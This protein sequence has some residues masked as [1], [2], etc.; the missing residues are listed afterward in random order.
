MRLSGMVLPVPRCIASFMLI[1]DARRRSESIRDLFCFH[2]RETRVADANRRASERANVRFAVVTLTHTP[3]EI[4][5]DIL[6]H[7]G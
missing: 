4:S 2:G 6:I 3:R 1:Y 5:Q 7:G